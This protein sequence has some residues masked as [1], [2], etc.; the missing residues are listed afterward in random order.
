MPK[1]PQKEKID[2]I[3]NTEIDD[4]IVSRAEKLKMKSE[5]VNVK[6]K[7]DSTKYITTGLGL[8][9]GLAWNDAIKAAIEHYLPP[10]GS[11]I[12]AKF[13]Y[14]TL[15]TFVVVLIGKFVFEGLAKKEAAVEIAKEKISKRLKSKTI[16]P[17]EVGASEKKTQKTA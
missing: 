13:F 17:K 10:S 15:I 8:V 16:K 4:K 9:A 3:K 2:L 5:E 12:I 14:A 1:K 7:E 6:F 11:T